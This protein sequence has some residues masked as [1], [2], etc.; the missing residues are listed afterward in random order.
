MKIN[1]RFAPFISAIIMG[2]IMAFL[3]SGIVTAIN[4]EGIN[5]DFLHKWFYA[6]T[7]VVFIVIPIIMIVRPIVEKIMKK[8]IDPNS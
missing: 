8:I 1:K 3:M 7:V 4:F 2:C 6:Y 5:E